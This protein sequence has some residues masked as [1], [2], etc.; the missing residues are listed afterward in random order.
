MALPNKIEFTN[1]FTIV[2]N[3]ASSGVSGTWNLVSGASGYNPAFN[4]GDLTFPDHG[5][6]VGLSDPNLILASG[7]IY[8]NF[9]D[10]ASVDQTT[11]LTSMTT[12]SG[13]IR[14]EQGAY[15]IEFAFTAGAFRIFNQSSVDYSVYWD[16]IPNSP[17][18]TLSLVSTSGNTFTDNPVTI[19][20]DI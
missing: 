11:L 10:A 9:I 15:H 6:N 12:N 2:P 7:S 4:N 19:T 14:L 13:T 20:I 3:N 1:G 5:P 18:G 17:T 8:I 16:N